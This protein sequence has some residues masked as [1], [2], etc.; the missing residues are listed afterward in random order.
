MI[1]F[2]LVAFLLLVC[3]FTANSTT[4]SEK[5]KSAVFEAFDDWQHLITNLDRNCIAFELS[6]PVKGNGR[7]I[8][9]VDIREIHDEKCGGD[10]Q[11]FPLAGSIKLEFSNSKNLE[12]VFIYDML[13]G[14]YFLVD[15]LR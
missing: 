8:V 7:L 5:M 10:P 12:R 11:T 4:L 13:T 3:P 2:R 9:D 6:E 1:M 14:T 15:A